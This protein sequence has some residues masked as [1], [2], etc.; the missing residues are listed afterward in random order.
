M[1]CGISASY[2]DIPKGSDLVLAG[3]LQ[4]DEGN[5]SSGRSTRETCE[6]DSLLGR[7]CNT[8]WVRSSL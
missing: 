2:R 8:T 3:T 5:V 7:W 6:R 1:G 4:M